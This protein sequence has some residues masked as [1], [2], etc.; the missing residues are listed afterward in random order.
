MAAL[1][2]ERA[3]W[4]AT[5]PALVVVEPVAVGEPVGPAVATREFPNALTPP[6][7]LTSLAPGA[8]ARVP[9]F[10][11]EP[12]L[13]AR[14]TT[15][16]TA[17]ASEGTVALTIPVI[18]QVPLIEVGALVDL[19]VVDGANL[20]SLRVAERVAV[21]AFSD[22]DVT[23]AVPPDQVGDATAASLRPVTITVV[24]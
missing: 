15:G 19:W 3:D 17:F 11:G 6:D 24:G 10:P 21:L 22:D 8:V 7:V 1:E 12:L 13:A 14:V 4:G 2:S 23:V 5:T 20:S 18:R 16:E 9:L